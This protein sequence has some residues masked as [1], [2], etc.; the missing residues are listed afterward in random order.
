MKGLVQQF[1][2]MLIKAPYSNKPIP[3]ELIGEWIE[4]KILN[5]RSTPS[6]KLLITTKEAT[7]L[8]PIGHKLRTLK[9][10]EEIT[11]KRY[12]HTFTLTPEHIS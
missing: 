6:S 2:E 4:E 11:K 3:K 5:R 7:V 9:D 1:E 10:Q 8:Y 12:K